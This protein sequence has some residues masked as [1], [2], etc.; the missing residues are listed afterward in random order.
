[1]TVVLIVVLYDSLGPPFGI[2]GYSK[3]PSRGKSSRDAGGRGREVGG[4]DLPQG[5]LPSNW[6]G[7]E[8]NHIVICLM[9][10]AADNDRRAYVALCR[11]EFRGLD[12]MLHRWWHK[13]R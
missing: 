13:E 2:L 12:L 1:M 11:H 6:C 10:K 4:P 8:P 9:L 5:V 7:I 3:W